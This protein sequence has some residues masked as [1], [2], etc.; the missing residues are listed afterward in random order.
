MFEPRATDLDLVDVENALLRGAVGDYADEAA[1]LLLINF[2]H[3]LSQLQSADLITVVPEPSGDGL[4]AQIA[5][6][7]LEPALATGLIAGSGGEVRM[8]R[9][10]ASIADGHPVDL[11]D[12]AGAL[13]RRPLTLLWT[14]RHPVSRRPAAAPG[15]VA[16]PRVSGARR[17][18]ANGRRATWP[19]LPREGARDAASTFHDAPARLPEEDAVLS[20]DETMAVGQA[21]YQDVIDALAAAGL[22]TA[23]T[24]TG[25]MNAALEVRLDGG[26]S[27]L[28]TDADDSLSWA[29]REQ[30]GWGVLLYPPEQA[31]D[32]EP[33][34]SGSATDTSTTTLLELIQQV[35]RRAVRG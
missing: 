32:G 35:L 31:Y 11:G 21:E 18:T 13:D 28:V 20:Y 4:W 26:Y 10:A 7:N 23:F 6:P 8:L 25:G 1:V 5:W 22:P 12:L 34:A 30:Q 17:T 14:R 2:G 27:L 24:Q 19:Q 15:D 3:W 33:L 29:R 16:P 9:A